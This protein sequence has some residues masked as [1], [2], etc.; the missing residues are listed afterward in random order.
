MVYCRSGL[1]YK[2]ISEALSVLRSTVTSVIVEAFGTTRQSWW[3]A[4]E[5]TRNSYCS[6]FSEAGIEPEGVWMLALHLSG[7]QTN[8][9]HWGFT[10]QCFW[11]NK[12]GIWTEET[13]LELF[14]KSHQLY[15]HRRGGKKWSF[16]RKHH[17]PP[18]W[19]MWEAQLCYR[20]AG[21]LE[22]VQGTT[23]SDDYRG[24]LKSNKLTVPERCVAHIGLF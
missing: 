24:D 22:S 8:V 18:L 21:S 6:S 16:Q 12:R 14:D 19:N 13:E 7:V 9:T 4:C 17:P 20:I 11:K 5:L 2:T 23:K 1:W 15:V 3:L 10:R